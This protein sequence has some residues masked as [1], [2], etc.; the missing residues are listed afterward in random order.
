M[1]P[2]RRR[3]TPTAPAPRLSKP[4]PGPGA[5]DIEAATDIVPLWVAESVVNEAAHGWRTALPADWP[6][7]LAARAERCF[8]G[9]RQF[10]RL[11]SAPV[12]GIHAL[13]RFMFHWL[14]GRVARSPPGAL[15]PPGRLPRTP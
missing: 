4:R 6:A 9:H 12:G 3:P 1:N 7:M 14:D 2:P 15:R 13:R 11:V 5:K 10:H 8:A